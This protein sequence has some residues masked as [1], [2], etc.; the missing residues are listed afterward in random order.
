MHAKNSVFQRYMTRSM[1]CKYWY[2][3]SLV[4]AHILSGCNI[5]HVSKTIHIESLIELTLIELIF[6]YVETNLFAGLVSLFF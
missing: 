3:D 1:I 6:E 4:K 2:F 5:P